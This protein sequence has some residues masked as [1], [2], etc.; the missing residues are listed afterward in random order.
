[1]NNQ[2]TNHHII[3]ALTS[4]ALLLLF[5]VPSYSQA[6]NGPITITIVA[7]VYQTKRAA[8]E[9]LLRGDRVDANL[10]IA[11]LQ[12][13]MQGFN[14]TTTITKLPALTTKSGQRAVVKGKDTI[15]EAE[16]VVGPDAQTVDLNA[17]LTVG[18]KHLTTTGTTKFGGTLFLGSLDGASPDTVQ[19]VFIRIL[20]Q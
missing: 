10:L 13:Q 17:A 7:E 5:I 2:T 1:M 8:A 4:L 16:P 9:P 19:L 11:A 20:K 18:E 14:S 12:K 3:A 15:L 6:D